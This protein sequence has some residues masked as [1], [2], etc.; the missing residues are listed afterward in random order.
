MMEEARKQAAKLG[1]GEVLED[2]YETD[3]AFLKQGHVKLLWNDLL[4]HGK[5]QTPDFTVWRNKMSVELVP[6]GVQRVLEV[7]IGMGHSL[8]YLSERFRNLEMYGT[9]SAQQPVQ[10]A[11]GA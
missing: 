10:Q 5:D 4:L 1:A 8:G 7:A 3:Y 9:D 6:R 11:A 2:L